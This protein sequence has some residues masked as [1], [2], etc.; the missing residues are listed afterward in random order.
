MNEVNMVG[1]GN[2]DMGNP[3]LMV[4]FQK[5]SLTQPQDPTFSL[6]N[7]SFVSM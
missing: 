7:H 5:C 2:L 4:K 6:I 3:I 1:E